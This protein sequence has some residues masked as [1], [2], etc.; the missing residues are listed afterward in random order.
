VR[1]VEAGA[2]GSYKVSENPHSSWGRSMGISTILDNS[3]AITAKI[4]NQ[5][6]RPQHAR[7]PHDEIGIPFRTANDQARHSARGHAVFGVVYGKLFVSV[8]DTP[9]LFLRRFVQTG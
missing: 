9:V 4:R 3:S 6:R 2:N 5:E 8:S 1:Y 7:P